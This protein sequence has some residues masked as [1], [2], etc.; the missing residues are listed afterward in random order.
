MSRQAPP[1]VVAGRVRY[2]TVQSP[3]EATKKRNGRRKR[4]DR[5]DVFRASLTEN[6]EEGYQETSNLAVAVTTSKS[7]HTRPTCPR[8]RQRTN[9]KYNHESFPQKLHRIVTELEVS[10]RSNIA[11]FLDDGGLRVQS[12]KI[13]VKQIM[14]LHF[15]ATVRIRAKR[16]QYSNCDG[17]PSAHRP[18]LA[19]CNHE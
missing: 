13:F 5:R 8:K 14:P 11:S 6:G 4:N 9:R 18:R 15:R 2:P 1:P 12:R 7:R 3:S 10:G 19:H 16:A 17:K